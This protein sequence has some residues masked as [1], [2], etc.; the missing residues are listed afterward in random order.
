MSSAEQVAR[1]PVANELFEK[2]GYRRVEIYLAKAVRGLEP[3]FNPT[4]MNFLLDE[5]GKEVRRNV[6]VNLYAKRLSSPSRSRP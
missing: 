3:L 4:V 5:D 1:C 6:L 2:S